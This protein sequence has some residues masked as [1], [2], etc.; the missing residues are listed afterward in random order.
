MVPH[1]P[2]SNSYPLPHG[3]CGANSS[4]DQREGSAKIIPT[5]LNPQDVDQTFVT[6][7]FDLEHATLAFQQHMDMEME[8][9]LRLEKPTWND[10][11]VLKTAVFPGRVDL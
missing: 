1:H 3:E 9:T 5:H 6:S 2:T 11:W 4:F 7:L 8:N 10:S